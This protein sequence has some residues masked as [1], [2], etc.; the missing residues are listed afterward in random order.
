MTNICLVKK[1]FILIFVFFSV[2][3]KAQGTKKVEVKNVRLVY[4]N[5]K[6][7]INYDIAETGK[8]YILVAFFNQAHV[9]L[10]AHT[11]YG[12]VDTIVLSGA[13][14]KITWD[15][16]RDYPLFNDN[17]YAEISAIALHDLDAKTTFLH[18]AIFPGY[19]SYQLTGSKVYLANGAL[20]YGCITA[21]L[22]FAY[23][24]KSN[25][26]SYKKSYISNE[27]DAFYNKAE[28]NRKISINLLYAGTGLFILN[29]GLTYLNFARSVKKYKALRNAK[30]SL[31]ILNNGD[32]VLSY[33]MDF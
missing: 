2:Q 23:K 16:K 24:S 10:N 6:L 9:K 33:K 8:F 19:G 15:I 31:N 30:L 14:K 11:L 21:S 27:R 13:A 22:W 12:D 25:Y 1:I 3:S 18:S 32:P 17:V 5:D 26:N 4:I 20:F 28:N 7:E 29:Y